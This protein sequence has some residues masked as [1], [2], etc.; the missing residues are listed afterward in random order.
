MAFD[1]KK[2]YKEYYLPPKEPGIIKI[3]AMHFIAVRGE[4]DPNEEGGAY[5]QAISLLYGIAFTI[6]MSDKGSH[7]IRGYF[8]YVVPPLE[9]LWWQTGSRKIDYT[10]KETFHWI[11]MIRLPDFVGKEEFN[12]AIAEA[13]EKKKTDFGKV[14]FFTY[15]DGECVQCMH[16]GPY[17]AEPATIRKMEAFAE[18]NGYEADIDSG[19]YHHEIYLG[20]PRKAAPGRLRTVIRQPV[21]K[22]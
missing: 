19:R 3:P 12:W 4:G 10:K 21:R 7:R 20:D 17:D 9:G 16:I 8:D 5:K 6:K 14:E 11:A 22:I 2:E 1:Y 15:E 13:T 18:E